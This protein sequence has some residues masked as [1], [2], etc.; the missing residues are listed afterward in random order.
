M[1]SRHE[2]EPDSFSVAASGGEEVVVPWP[3][4]RRLRQRAMA[5]LSPSGAPVGGRHHRW[6]VLWTV[7]AGLFSVNV[8]F[9]IFAVALTQVARGL[10]TTTSDATW[11]I[12]A[13]LLCFGVAAPV[14]GKLGD[15]WG[16]RRLYLAGTSAAVVAAVM[17]AAAPNVPLLIVARALSGVVG[18]AAGAASMALIFRVFDHQDRVKAMGWWS[19]VGAGGPVIGVVAGGVLITDFGWR[20]LFWVQ[21][22]LTL[23]SVVV[24]AVVLPETERADAGSFDW[25]GAG[26]ITV[27]VFA[28]LFGLN[29]GPVLGWTSPVVAGSFVVFPVA[30]AAFVV[31]ERKTPEPLLPLGFLRRRNFAFPIANQMFGQ[32]AYMG[33]F[34][35]APALLEQVFGFTASRAGV[36]VIARPLTFSLVAPIAG[37]VAGRVGDRNA[38]V[39]GSVVLG[40]SM[41]VFDAVGHGSSTFLVVVALAL[42][43]L[44]LGIASPSVTAAV[45][46]TVEEN[47][48]GVAS[49]AQQLMNQ[50]GTVAGIQ[51]LQ[52][53]Q[54]A[55]QASGL[56]GSFHAAYLVGAAA[57][58]VAAACG[59]GMLGRRAESDVEQAVAM[60]DAAAV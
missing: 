43:G 59:M 12:T 38:A 7:L 33:G 6:W 24:A 17:T 49:A 45:A 55:R 18:A 29:R 21:A 51:V 14:L 4:I 58:V 2:T 11:V 31:A 30:L 40:L 13:P 16:H 26:A 28:L 5:S 57:C 20:A 54:A 27:A 34:I 9:T 15:T 41:L 36:M 1:T 39:T 44:G 35:L 10:H 23:V 60:A 37:Y 32:F 3:A 22:P 50:V 46:N 25:W 53:V 19:L 47:S 42:S 8:T 48:L 52:T 56:L